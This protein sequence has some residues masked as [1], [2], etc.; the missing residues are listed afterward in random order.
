[1]RLT[2]VAFLALLTSAASQ[3]SGAVRQSSAHAA[4]TLNGTDTAHLHLIHQQETV[5]S[6]EG[7]ATGAL[8]GHMRA[9]LNIGAVYTGRCTI[10][11]SGGT[12]T[13]RG[14]AIP[15]GAGRY[16]SFHGSLLITGGTGRY[17]HVHGHTQLYGTFD[18]RTFAVVIQTTGNLSY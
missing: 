4:R 16:Q 12:V 11:T 17:A 8:P 10:Y 3:A 18:R 5:L 2:I 7:P 9:R 6:E 13:G 14:T 15:H 1:M